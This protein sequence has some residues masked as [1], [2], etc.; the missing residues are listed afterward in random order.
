MGR[1]S[2][3]WIGPE[4]GF[5][6][7]CLEA[8][9]S[10]ITVTKSFHLRYFTCPVGLND[11]RFSLLADFLSLWLHKTQEESMQSL[12]CLFSCWLHVGGGRSIVA[13]GDGGETSE[14]GKKQSSQGSQSAAL[15][16]ATETRWP[17]FS[18]SAVGA[19]LSVY[20]HLT[21]PSHHH[22]KTHTFTCTQTHRWYSVLLGVLQRCKCRIS[23]FWILFFSPEEAWKDIVK[24]GCWSQKDASFFWL[25]ETSIMQNTFYGLR[26][27]K[28]TCM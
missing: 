14:P 20:L 12:T 15:S 17:S 13:E 1:A 8:S 21:W 22:V 6:K 27:K 11:F 2:M 9:P 23:V 24:V 28:W 10:L 18:W 5:S 16:S 7:P 26:E 19:Y 4:K 3:S 25:G